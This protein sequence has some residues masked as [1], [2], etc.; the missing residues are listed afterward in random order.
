MG[1]GLQ[2]CN[3]VKCV[4]DSF[5]SRDSAYAINIIGEDMYDVYNCGTPGNLI[6]ESLAS[7]RI[8]TSAFLYNSTDISQS[9]YCANC[10]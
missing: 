1:D 4:F 8:S 2:N 5:H 9:Y 7:Y 3:S 6:L 10:H